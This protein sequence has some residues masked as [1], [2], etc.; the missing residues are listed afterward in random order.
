MHR[1]TL[2]GHRPDCLH[3]SQNLVDNSASPLTSIITNANA[4]WKFLANP[5]DPDTMP[6][7]P[8]YPLKFRWLEC[9]KTRRRAPI[10]NG[11]ST[12]Y[13]E[14]IDCKKHACPLRGVDQLLI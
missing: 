5:V 9:S 11:Y 10:A 14:M 6:S 8:S 2:A 1:L 7:I 13:G 4:P 3:S 12:K